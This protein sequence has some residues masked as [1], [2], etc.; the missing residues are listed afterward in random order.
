MQPSSN[1]GCA[2]IAQTDS[3]LQ[4]RDQNCASLSKTALQFAPDVNEWVTLTA[5]P[6]EV[7]IE[8]AQKTKGNDRFF[9]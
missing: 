4:K 6:R 1:L 2:P 8:E 5:D 9:I 7:A 3:L